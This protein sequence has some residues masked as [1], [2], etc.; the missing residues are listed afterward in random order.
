MMLQNHSTLPYEYIIL[1][2]TNVWF[3]LHKC[4]I[5]SYKVFVIK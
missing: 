5:V 1:L 3:Q 2:T 4:L